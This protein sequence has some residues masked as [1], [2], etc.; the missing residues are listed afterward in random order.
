MQAEHNNTRARLEPKP[1]PCPCRPQ[2]QR[3]AGAG[4]SAPPPSRD[5][6]PGVRAISGWVG[7]SALQQGEGGALVRAMMSGG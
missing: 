1:P 3:S 6:R 2:T 7:G 5:K 4:R